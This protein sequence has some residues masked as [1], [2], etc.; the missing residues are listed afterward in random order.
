MAT[1]YGETVHGGISVLSPCQMS[2]LR[3]HFRVDFEDSS[4]GYTPGELAP[5]P[6]PSPPTAPT[7]CTPQAP[8]GTACASSTSANP[9]PAAAPAHAHLA[10]ALKQTARFA[11]AQADL[12]LLHGCETTPANDTVDAGQL[13]PA[14]RAVRGRLAASKGGGALD[15]GAYGHLRLLLHVETGEVLAGGPGDD[16]GAVLV[17]Q[18]HQ[19]LAAQHGYP[20]VLLLEAHRVAGLPVHRLPGGQVPLRIGYVIAALLLLQVLLGGVGGA[21]LVLCGLVDA[22]HQGRRRGAL[23]GYQVGHGVGSWIR[24]V[25]GRRGDGEQRGDSEQ[26]D[27]ADR[28]SVPYL[29]RPWG[30][31]RGVLLGDL[32]TFP[33]TAGP[34]SVRPVV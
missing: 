8:K 29:R 34:L 26:C 11:G 9:P 1:P 5:A 23:T 19:I 21:A 3:W 18:A 7:R 15:S 10:W 30:L 16:P 14:S 31:L 20:L 32:F 12:P 13:G 27:A 17:L 4:G 33:S 24:S 28:A 6:S 25:G 22:V 2:S